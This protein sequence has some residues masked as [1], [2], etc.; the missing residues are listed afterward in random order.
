MN[1]VEERQEDNP[2]FEIGASSILGTRNYQ[3]DYA[4]FYTG[5]K[6]VLGVVCDGMGGLEGGERA[7]RTAVELMIRDFHST[8]N[9]GFV[10]DFL[11]RTARRMDQAVG[12][13]EGKNGKPLRAGTTLVAAYCRENQMYWVSV[14]D[15]KIYVI[16]GGEIISLNREH[17]YRL[18]LQMQLESGLIDQA[19]YQKE[20]RKPQAE[21]LISFIGMDPAKY[22]DGN[23]KPQILQPGDIIM[24]CS[25]GIY[26]SLNESQVHA[27]VRDNDLDMK[28]AADRVT[29]MAMR[30]GVRGQ[31]NTTAV[32]MKYLGN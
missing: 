14:G 20:E 13:L 3:Q 22:I 29:A 16:R 11:A 15:S 27:M 17:N 19:F 7:S 8:S 32:L 26:K 28:I 10:P 18:A 6:C 12:A 23:Q 21:A 2:W 4:Y 1:I 30:Y 31:D 24:L 9:L 25:D 5:E